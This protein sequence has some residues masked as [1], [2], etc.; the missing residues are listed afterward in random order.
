MTTAADPKVIIQ[1]VAKI[2]TDAMTANEVAALPDALTLLAQLELL[3]PPIDAPALD[4]GDRAA[5]DVEVD[6]EV[7]KT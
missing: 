3:I 7:S 4:P 1:Q 2:I 5:V 6:A